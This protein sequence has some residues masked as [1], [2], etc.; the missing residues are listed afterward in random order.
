[1]SQTQSQAKRRLRGGT[2]RWNDC[3]ICL[4]ASKD[5][6]DMTQQSA[7][8]PQY[9]ARQKKLL[10]KELASRVLARRN[11]LQYTKR[12]HP[13]YDAGWVHEDIC[14]RLEKFSQDV[15]EKKSPRLMLLVPPRHGKSELASIRFPAWHL[16]HHPDHEII[17]AGYNMDLPMKFSRKVREQ[18]RDKAYHAMFPDTKLDPDSQSVEAWNTLAG[19]G[20]TAAGVGGGITGK[21]A[22]CVPAETLI[23]TE[24]GALTAFDL[25]QYNT[26]IRVWSFDHESNQFVLRHVVAKQ[27][28]QAKSVIELRTESGRALR[29]TEDHRVFIKQQGYVAAGQVRAG[30]QLVAADMR[31]LRGGLPKTET[32]DKKS[33][34]VRLLGNLLLQK[35][36]SR[37]SRYQKLQAVFDVLFPSL[38][39]RA[40]QERD[41]LLSTVSPS[42]CTH[43]AVP[44]VRSC[45]CGENQPPDV[46]HSTLRKQGSFGQ[47]EGSVEFSLSPR[48]ELQPL[49][50][51]DEAANLGTRQAAVRCV[52]VN[53]Q[54]VCP[55]FG[56]EQGKQSGE[57]PHHDVPQVSHEAPQ[58]QSDAVSVVV[59][60]RSGGEWVYD[61][62]VDGTN[63]FVADE[64]LVHN[65]L[66]IDDPVKNMEEA[67]SAVIR[68]SLWDW[69]WSTAYTRLAPGGGVLLVQTWWS[70]DDL[71]GRLQKKMRDEE[72]S[73]QFVIIKYPALAEADEY[74]A[75]DGDL[76]RVNPDEPNAS[77]PEGATLLRTKGEALHPER[78]PTEMMENYRANMHPRVWSALY[79]QN[80]VPDEGMY[81]KQEWFR[82]EPTPPMIRKRAIYQ[83]WDFAIG[84]RQ[85]NDY[86]VGATLLQD[87][88]NFLHVLDIVRFKG[89]TFVIIEEI[90][91][92]LQ[93]WTLYPDTPVTLGFEDGQ[94]WRAIKPVLELRM[95]ERNVF[96]AYEVLKPLTD[97]LVRARALQGRMQQGRVMF[98]QDAD[99]FP[100]L[101]REMLR[102][103]AG[104]HDD[105]CDALAWA[106]NLIAGKAPPRV[107]DGQPQLKSWRDK[108]KGISR[109]TVTHMA[110]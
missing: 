104:Q 16:G 87:E 65:C 108:L 76:L 69:Y 72:L 109:Q 82:L 18:L 100:E 105:Q 99:W 33:S 41:V 2:A 23:L 44:T 106:C 95:A 19:G 50:R 51:L 31:V 85:Q 62:Q 98:L 89:D 7:G 101:Q 61:F 42:S 102:F 110:A 32:S 4:A 27:R 97:K 5:I 96:P 74:L 73:D 88:N 17:N 77:P 63:N 21:G 36:L 93:K 1:L 78:Y 92:A 29:C 86:T 30:D 37:A 56:R 6:F 48:D 49:V 38:G 28:K 9:Q 43:Q 70:D 90:L 66:I 80:P 13:H 103:P 26:A 47:D 68:D 58:V 22:H 107:E 12:F 53:L 15:V 14:R 54:A 45:V 84:E 79:Q 11:L 34:S 52:C 35:V 10:E 39:Q 81:F 46:L 83:A 64:I 24:H 25:Y 55:S 20:L 67:D 94:I 40:K 59:E 91:N 75:Q 60:L 57:Q 71:A 8:S 3:L